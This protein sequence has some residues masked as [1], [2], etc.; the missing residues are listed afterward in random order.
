MSSIEIE[1]HGNFLHALAIDRRRSISAFPAVVLNR[2]RIAQPTQWMTD[3]ESDWFRHFVSERR[4][5]TP[6]KFFKQ[7]TFSEVNQFCMRPKFIA[8]VTAGLKGHYPLVSVSR[9]TRRNA[10]SSCRRGRA[11]SPTRTSPSSA[12]GPPTPMMMT[13]PTASSIPSTVSDQL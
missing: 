6:K 12:T 3:M 10:T 7:A 9:S 11:S 13:S 2:V 1:S 4:R 8:H 5:D